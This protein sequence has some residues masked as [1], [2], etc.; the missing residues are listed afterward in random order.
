MGARNI[1]RQKLMIKMRLIEVL[2][3]MQAKKL[4]KTL[5]KKLNKMR[6]KQLNKTQAKQLHILPI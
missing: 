6:A 1:V 3:T 2:K 5:L 4:N